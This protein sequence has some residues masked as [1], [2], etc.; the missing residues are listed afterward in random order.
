MEIKR[1]CLCGNEFVAKSGA[2]KWCED[3]RRE[4][5]MKPTRSKKRCNKPKTINEVLCE[6]E[7]Y[8]KEHGTN[9]SYGKYFLRGSNH[10]R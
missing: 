3:C 7:Q 5:N 6:I 1:I 8:N 10:V 4:M 9:L 2:A